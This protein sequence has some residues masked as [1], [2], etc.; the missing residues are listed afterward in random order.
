MAYQKIYN[1]MIS[2]NLRYFYYYRPRPCSGWMDAVL[3][4]LRAFQNKTL[5]STTKMLI[6]LLTVL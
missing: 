3:D 2:K 4:I 1:C 6:V 5:T